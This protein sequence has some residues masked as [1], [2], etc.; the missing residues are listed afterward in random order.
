MTQI[1]R[2]G[3]A[4][5]P[6]L[7]ALLCFPA[8]GAV[9]PSNLSARPKVGILR[10]GELATAEDE[11]AYDVLE[12]RVQLWLENLSAP[13]PEVQSLGLSLRA[14]ELEDQA[15]E[16][17]LARLANQVLGNRDSQPDPVASS[18]MKRLRQERERA[19]KRGPVVQRAWL[20]EALLQIAEGKNAAAVESL[21]SA[22]TM[23]PDAATP[24]LSRWDDD[25]SGT[26]LRLDTMLAESRAGIVRL[27]EAEVQSSPSHASLSVNGFAQGKR[28][29]FHLPPGK[30]E[31][32]FQAPGFVAASETIDCSRTSRV[33]RT[34]AMKKS[35]DSPK[36]YLSE[37][38]EVRQKNA[39]GSLFLIQ[40]SEGEFRFYLLSSEGRMDAIPMSRPL[41]ISEVSHERALPIS[42]DEMRTLLLRHDLNRADLSFPGPV[43]DATALGGGSGELA[44]RVGG[45]DQ[46]YNDWQVWA[47]VGGV[48]A[49]VLGAYL[50][51]RGPEIKTKSGVTGRWE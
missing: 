14:G 23:H 29:K 48:A 51:T 40:P 13:R 11:K 44:E 3:K 24:D 32:Q 22:L 15:E 50:M 41:K 10:V 27:C 43:S 9:A 42:R 16:Q 6:L 38:E 36:G 35:D 1:R 33:K 28:R 39:V 26:L 21:R 19:G 12:K 46:W 20:A 8:P 7:V 4:V 30:F 25:A 34:V 2:T 5:V 45:K 18:E 37:L 47:V 31:F 49:G 17:E